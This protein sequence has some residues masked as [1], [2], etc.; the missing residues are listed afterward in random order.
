MG[1]TQFTD[2]ANPVMYSSYSGKSGRKNRNYYKHV[3]ANTRLMPA[4]IGPVSNPHDVLAGMCHPHLC[5]VKYR[6]MMEDY[7]P[8]GLTHD[9]PCSL[10]SR[11]VPECCVSEPVEYSSYHFTMMH[12]IS[13]SEHGLPHCVHCSLV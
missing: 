8:A 10:Y 7:K 2:L 4:I 11:L 3:L 9:R 5:S 13:H 12:I 1:R 6:F